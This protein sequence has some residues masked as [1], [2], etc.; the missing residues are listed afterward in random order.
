MPNPGLTL[1]SAVNIYGTTR[2]I[3]R[4]RSPL[5]FPAVANSSAYAGGKIPSR[6]CWVPSGAAM[7]DVRENSGVSKIRVEQAELAGRRTVKDA[8]GN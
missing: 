7:R 8:R 1:D 5:S 3:K 2:N 6:L 4:R